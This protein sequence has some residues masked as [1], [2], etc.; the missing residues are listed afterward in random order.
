MVKISAEVEKKFIDRLEILTNKSLSDWL[1]TV[2]DTGISKRNDIIKWLKE[3]HNFGHKYASLLVGIYL[4][5]GK[6]VYKSEDELLENQVS[7]YEIWRPLFESVSKEIVA[8]FPDATMIAKKYYISFTAKREFAAIDIKLIEI[9]LYMDL[10][11]MPFGNTLEKAMLSGSMSRFS[12]MV[13]LRNESDFNNL[14]VKWLR[15]SYNR[16]NY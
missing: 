5:N 3:T 7:K 10:G 11:N 9:R 14:V 2:K 16:V 8:Q 6:P 15:E 4:N 12:H 13:I 1:G